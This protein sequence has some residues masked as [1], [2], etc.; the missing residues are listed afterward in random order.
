MARLAAGEDR[1][2]RTLC[3]LARTRTELTPMVL[4]LVRAGVRHTAAVPPIVDAERVLELVGAA[5][6]TRDRGHPFHVLRRLRAGR[7]WDRGSP[8]GDLLSDD[9]HAALDAMLGWATAFTTVDAF[10]NAFADARARID[11]LRDP[12]AP[13]ELATVHASKGREWETVVL[14]GFEADRIPN[15]RS[16]VD[17][18]DST[19]AMEEERRL[20]YVAVTRATR[21]LILAFDPARPSPFLGEMGFAAR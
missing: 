12:A 16:L 5:R 13:V 3:F 1:A 6:A 15:R 20:A 9:D 4:A 2:D 21:R 14:L 10:A 7:G 17:A 11:A 8:S 18:E 19:R